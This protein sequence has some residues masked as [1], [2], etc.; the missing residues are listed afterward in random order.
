MDASEYRARRARRGDLARRSTS[1]ASARRAILA[2]WRFADDAALVDRIAS[3]VTLVESPET[4]R[5]LGWAFG[6]APSLV[7]SAPRTEFEFDRQVLNSVPGLVGDAKDRAAV[8][9]YLLGRIGEQL[10]LH[11]ITAAHPLPHANDAAARALFDDLFHG[12]LGVRTGRSLRTLYG[13]ATRR[14]FA[15]V[16]TDLRLP[17]SWMTS[18]LAEALDALEFLAFDGGWVEVAVRML[19]GT[20]PPVGALSAALDGPGAALVAQC[21]AGR[22]SW[23][24]TA[25]VLRVDDS[26]GLAARLPVGAD[27]HV[28]LRLVEHFQTRV[29]AATSLGLP[30]WLIVTQ[31]RGKIRGRLR[32]VLARDPARLPPAVLG[33]DAFYARSEAAFSR[34]AWDWAWREAKAGFSFGTGSLRTTA[35]A[36]DQEPP[37][38]PA[39]PLSRAAVRTTVLL[40]V[41]RGVRDELERWLDGEPSAG[42]SHKF[43]RYLALAPD[44]VADPGGRGRSYFRLRDHLEE[45]ISEH[46]ADVAAV[47]R[48]VAAVP[49][50][51]R[52]MREAMAQAL[53]PEWDPTIIPFPESGSEAVRASLLA[54]LATYATSNAAGGEP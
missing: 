34:F 19:E 43:Y 10:A 49:V 44:S 20:A 45:S 42:L 46:Y 38:P 4:E 2:P 9:W 14:A 21:V 28:F 13:N 3:R 37:R 17:A 11:D 22:A 8:A 30:G 50:S 24:A 5:L 32:Q 27:L 54:F 16:G 39:P 40:L 29:P 12:R 47:A 26:A 53:A 1:D 48:R 15:A 41:A 52:G 33:L 18:K 25:R 36:L 7:Q 35:C 23:G 51:R 6:P 31:N